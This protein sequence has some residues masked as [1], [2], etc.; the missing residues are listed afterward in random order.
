MNEEYFET[1]LSKKERGIEKR[2]AQ[3]KEEIQKLKILAKK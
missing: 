2:D 1:I 3:F